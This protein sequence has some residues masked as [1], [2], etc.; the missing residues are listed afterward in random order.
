MTPNSKKKKINITEDPRENTRMH[1]T[2]K[3]VF[4]LCISFITN[5]SCSAINLYQDLP[6]CHKKK[7][8]TIN[9]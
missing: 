1:T 9:K 2:Y 3:N 8:Y 7:K 6:K 4:S 5:C